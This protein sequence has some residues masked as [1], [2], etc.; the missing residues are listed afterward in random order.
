MSKR[1][2]L[3]SNIFKSLAEERQNFYSVNTL[4][5]ESSGVNAVVAPTM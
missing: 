2:Q 3:G 4:S 1:S 5:S